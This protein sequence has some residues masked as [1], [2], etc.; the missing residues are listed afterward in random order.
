MIS[1]RGGLVGE[2]LTLQLLCWLSNAA[3]SFFPFMSNST[4]GSVEKYQQRYPRVQVKMIDIFFPVEGFD[5][6]T[7]RPSSIK[8]MLING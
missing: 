5:D 4:G 7:K 1:L 8:P 6:P 3:Q 2:N